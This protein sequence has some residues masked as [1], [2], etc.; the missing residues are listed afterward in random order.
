MIEV[1]QGA[2]ARDWLGHPD[3]VEAWRALEAACP[4]PSPYTGPAFVR[5]ALERSGGEPLLVVSADPRG[6]LAGI[7]PFAVSGQR[8]EA[9]GGAAAREQGW[10]AAPLR[11]AFFAEAALSA[12]LDRG[13]DAELA[14]PALPPGAPLDWA[15]GSRPMASRVHLAA[16]ACRIVDLSVDRVRAPLDDK[17]NSAQLSRLRRRGALALAPVDGPEERVRWLEVALAWSDE[18]RFETGRSPEFRGDPGRVALLADLA[19]AGVL[20]VDTLRSGDQV[21]AV[22]GTLAV[23]ARAV[24]EVAAEDP[25]EEGAAPGLVLWLLLEERLAAEGLGAVDVSHGPEWLGLMGAPHPAA[26]AVLTFAR[27]DALRRRASS[28]LVD[29]TRWVLDRLDR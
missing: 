24:V 19:R 3:R 10:T 21:L 17:A 5:G 2:D 15:R 27:R 29:L 11:S 22:V 25:A 13:F 6:G 12:L 1:L 4:H 9:P 26:G 14:L 18:R 23:G 28:G 8:L 16:R 20:R 7:W